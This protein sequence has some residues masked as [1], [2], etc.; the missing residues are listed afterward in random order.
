MLMICVD[1]A[2]EFTNAA[3]EFT[4]A[5]TELTPML[6]S[7]GSLEV[8]RPKTVWLTSSQTLAQAASSAGRRLGFC[9]RNATKSFGVDLVR[10]TVQKERLKAIHRRR[11]RF[12]ML[13]HAGVD[14]GKLLRTEGCSAMACGAEIVGADLTTYQPDR[15]AARVCFSDHSA[16]KAPTLDLILCRKQTDRV[17]VLNAVPPAQWSRAV[18]CNAAPR[19]W[20]H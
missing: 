2:T 15:S 7:H 6:E 20:Q 18:W 1:A 11:C 8:S 12:R 19:R 9:Q 13:G 5:T 3:T 16:G 14:V 10:R 17:Y 4:N